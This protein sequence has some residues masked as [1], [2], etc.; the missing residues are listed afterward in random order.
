M[1]PKWREKEAIIVSQE[2]YFI[3]ETVS[4]IQHEYSQL[5]L[6]SPASLVSLAN[7]FLA[8]FSPL[9]ICAACSSSLVF[10]LGYCVC[11]YIVLLPPNDSLISHRPFTVSNLLISPILEKSSVAFKNLNN[12]LLPPKESSHMSK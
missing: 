2:K 12:S 1:T 11:I 5:V 6:S 4:A 8:L 9:S 7:L 10:T 3:F